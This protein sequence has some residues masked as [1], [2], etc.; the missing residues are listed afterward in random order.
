[1]VIVSG[2]VLPSRNAPTG[3]ELGLG[4]LESCR[5]SEA[6]KMEP[7]GPV[8]IRPA[9]FPAGFTC[10][11]ASRGPLRDRLHPRSLHDPLAVLVDDL[12]ELDRGAE[13]PF[14]VAAADPD[15]AV[16][17]P[18]EFLDPEEQVLSRFPVALVGGQDGRL[19]AL[20]ALEE[21][22]ARHLLS[23]QRKAILL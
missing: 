2:M 9:A 14:V 7:S 19:V 21:R 1:M 20:E 3:R 13:V 17:T 8:R 18:V 23:G 15:L 5:D 6:W 10:K 4:S 12:E 22:R 16:L 11:N